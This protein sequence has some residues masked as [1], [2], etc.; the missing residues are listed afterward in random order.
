MEFPNR[1]V[2]RQPPTY[3]RCLGLRSEANPELAASQ[4]W[5]DIHLK[6]RLAIVPDVKREE[7]DREERFLTV[8]NI[9]TTEVRCSKQRFL[10]GQCDR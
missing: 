3:L 10:V 5:E 8:G 7:R 4:A 2:V 6:S 9:H 1:T